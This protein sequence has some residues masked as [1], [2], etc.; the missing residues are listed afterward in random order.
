[1]KEGAAGPHP[2]GGELKLHELII[3]IVSNTSHLKHAPDRSH[4]CEVGIKDY[5]F[6]RV[7]SSILG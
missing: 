7:S 3:I 2:A 4:D 1:M 5:I 6:Y